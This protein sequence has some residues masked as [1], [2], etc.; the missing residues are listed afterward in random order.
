MAVSSA[1]RGVQVLAADTEEELR[2]VMAEG[3][4]LVLLNRLLD[5]GF[6][7][8]E[9]VKLVERLRETHPGL[10]M[11]LVSNFQEAQAAAVAAGA[12]PG[13]GKREIGSAR[14]KE[15]IREALEI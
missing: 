9:G 11:M 13:F 3:V 8:Q 2:Q 15:V 5:F 14:V 4:D 6:A 10:K 12:L 1:A 7:E